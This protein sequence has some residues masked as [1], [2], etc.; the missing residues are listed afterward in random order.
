MWENL[1]EEK[2][3]KQA[4]S[5]AAQRNSI[6][7]GPWYFKSKA[8]LISFSLQIK[9]SEVKQSVHSNTAIKQGHELRSDFKFCG[10]HDTQASC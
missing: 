2:S 1:Q 7:S 8:G 4:W 5:G 10:V 9:L 3:R 6:C